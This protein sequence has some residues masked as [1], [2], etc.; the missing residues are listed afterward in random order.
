MVTEKQALSEAIG[1]LYETFSDYPLAQKIEGCPCCVSDEDES[2]LHRKPLREL[3]AEDLTRYAT[4]ALTTWG[5]ENDFKHFLPRLFEL[6][7][8]KDGIAYEIDLAILFGKLDYAAWNTWDK[9][10]RTAVRRYL[11]ALWVF[12]LSVP[13][14]AVT[15]EEYLCAL[16]QAEEDLSWYLDTW[17]SLQSDTAL[18]HLVEFVEAQGSLAKG[19]LTDAFWGGRRGQILQIIGWLKQNGFA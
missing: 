7:T 8:E 17:Q 14:E 9:R 1:G 3:T 18:N 11:K 4:K 15:I 19:K 2:S 6:V 10:E 12:V 5:T 16:S 13:T